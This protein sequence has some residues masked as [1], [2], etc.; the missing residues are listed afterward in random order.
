M[1][2]EPKNCHH[3]YLPPLLRNRLTPARRE[4][5]AWMELTKWDY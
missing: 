5:T 1:M 4:L 3:F 2:R